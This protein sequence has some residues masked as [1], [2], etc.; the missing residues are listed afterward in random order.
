MYLVV[1]HVTIILDTI[2]KLTHFWD[3]YYFICLLCPYIYD[4]HHGSISTS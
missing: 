1:I 3:V 2:Q 4:C